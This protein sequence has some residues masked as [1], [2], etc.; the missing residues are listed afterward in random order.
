MIFFILWKM[1]FQRRGNSVDDLLIGTLD[2]K[3]K[4]ELNKFM[5]KYFRGGEGIMVFIFHDLY[6][7]ILFCIDTTLRYIS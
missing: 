2:A 5:I 4:Y 6:L 1:K 7:N 3:F